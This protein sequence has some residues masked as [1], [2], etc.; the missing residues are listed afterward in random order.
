MNY[1]E[2]E[3]LARLKSRLLRDQ[4]VL[5]RQLSKRENL[6][7]KM[8]LS[9]VLNMVKE[10]DHTKNKSNLKDFISS[11]ELAFK[12]VKAADAANLLLYVKFQRISGVVA[13]GLELT[14]ADTWNEL[15]THLLNTYEEKHDIT[16]VQ[17]QF[18]ALKQGDGERV[19]DYGERTTNILSNLIQGYQ[20]FMANFPGDFP[21]HERLLRA[22][23]LLN[24][25]RGLRR[26]LST[27]NPG[28]LNQVISAAKNEEILL[29][30]TK[31]QSYPEGFV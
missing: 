23:A 17:A 24:F 8:D 9:S 21:A 12:L 25:T 26:E 13:Q 28:N 20:R 27:L 2:E 31:N 5:N 18:C 22:Q 29:P 15:K 30:A 11:A 19:A 1:F 10:F 14:Q 4:R 3:D 16:Y 6:E 7:R